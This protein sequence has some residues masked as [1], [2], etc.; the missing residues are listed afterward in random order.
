MRSL[1]I[2]H[3]LYSDNYDITLAFTMLHKVEGTTVKGTRFTC[4]SS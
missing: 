3:V 1:G 4:W 2:T